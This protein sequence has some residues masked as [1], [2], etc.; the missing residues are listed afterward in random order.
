MI[1]DNENIVSKLSEATN[2][3]VFYEL[4]VQELQMPCITYSM[5]DNNETANGNKMS[6]S[7]VAY[8]IKLW[9]HDLADMLPTYKIIDAT[10]HDLGYSRQSYNEMAIDDFICMI[11]QYRGV[12]IEERS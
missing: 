4:F 1:W 7:E 8:Y 12:G 9:G 10:M 2:L 3:Q 6:H 11:G 5:Y